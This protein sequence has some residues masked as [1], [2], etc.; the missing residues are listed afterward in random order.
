MEV[1][2]AHLF[3]ALFTG[4]PLV[5]VWRS[6]P[7][8]RLP[9]GVELVVVVWIAFLVAQG[10]FDHLAGLAGLRHLHHRIANL[11]LFKRL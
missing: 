11:L 5:P 4:D 8:L 7:L 9:L 2:C 10:L 6:F 3:A 1:V